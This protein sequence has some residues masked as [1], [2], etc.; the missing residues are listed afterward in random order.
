MERARESEWEVEGEGE[1]DER[2]WGVTR[3]DRDPV[4]ERCADFNNIQGKEGSNPTSV[5]REVGRNRTF[6][7]SFCKVTFHS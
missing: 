4:A 7:Q 6:L 3:A 1:R 5:D 2:R